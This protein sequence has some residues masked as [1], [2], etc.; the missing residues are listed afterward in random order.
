M[1][2]VAL[3]DALSSAAASVARTAGV[4]RY[5]CTYFIVPQATERARRNK[6]TKGTNGALKGTTGTTGAEHRYAPVLLET[7]H[8][9]LRNFCH[10][11]WEDLAYAWHVADVSPTPAQS[12]H[13]C[14][15]GERQSRRRCGNA[16]QHSA[17]VS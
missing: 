12:R 8:G 3:P 14:G 6:R 2:R 9:P 7:S 5:S 10:F 17:E 15:R 13:R 1:L 16:A 11:L 4:L